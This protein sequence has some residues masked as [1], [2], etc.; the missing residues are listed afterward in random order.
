MRRIDAAHRQGDDH[1]GRPE[2][3]AQGQE[4]GPR[5]CCPTTSSPSRAGSSRRGDR[6]PAPPRPRPSE[7]AIDVRYYAD[8]L[9]RSRILIA[10]AAVLG[11]GLGLLVAFVQTPEYRASVMLQ[12]EPPTP[13]FM[14]VTDALV[15][16][17]NYWQNADFY[18]TQFKV[19]RSSASARRCVE[20]L[21]LK[22]RPPF[23]DRRR[24]A[25]TFMAHVGVEPVPGEPAGPDPRHAPRPEGGGALGEHAGRRLHR[26]DALHARGS[27]R[28]RPTSGCRSAWPPPRRACARPRTGC[29]RATRARTC[30]C[31]RAAS[32]P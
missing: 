24:R 7:G 18:N 3:R 5:R 17:G 27:R 22:D 32:P 10:T 25:G 21:K 26:G 14:S 4:A 2:G 31:P 11:L 8:L 30:S 19:L 9:W 13:T 15:G 23:K 29:S 28:A 20:R 1:E 12:I 16:G 6:L